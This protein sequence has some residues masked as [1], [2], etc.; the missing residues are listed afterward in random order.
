MALAGI[1]TA[2]IKRGAI[3][4]ATSNRA[5]ADLNKVHLVS[6]YGYLFISLYIFMH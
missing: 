4:V 3:I 2:L 6:H 1:F 5:P